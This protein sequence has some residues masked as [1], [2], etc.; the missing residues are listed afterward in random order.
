MQYFAILLQY[1]TIET[2]PGAATCGFISYFFDWGD[3]ITLFY[4]RLDSEKLDMQLW[5][6]KK[7]LMPK[8][9]NFF[10]VISKLE[11]NSLMRVANLLVPLFKINQGNI[12]LNIYG[13]KLGSLVIQACVAPIVY[14]S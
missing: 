11:K 9:F 10:E 3:T 4:E 6:R 5:N 13:G 1:N 7:V 8:Q 12:G 14:G 2:T